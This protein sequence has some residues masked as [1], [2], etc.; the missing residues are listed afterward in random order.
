MGCFS[1][2]Q[3]QSIFFGDA[4]NGRSENAG[5]ENAGTNVAGPEN[6]GT[7]RNAASLVSLIQRADTKGNNIA[8]RPRLHSIARQKLYKI[9]L[10]KPMNFKVRKC[11][12]NCVLII[13]STTQADDTNSIQCNINIVKRSERRET[14]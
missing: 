2:G 7:P 10:I 6:A 12:I 4:E 5:P 1:I 14:Q 3:T 11:L 8:R 13:F 9:K